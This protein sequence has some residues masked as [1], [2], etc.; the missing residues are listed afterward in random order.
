[1]EDLLDLVFF[2]IDLFGEYWFVILGYFVY[3]VLGIDKD[4]KKRKSPPPLTPVNP[5]MMPG[6]M[7]AEK[8]P[9]PPMVMETTPM[10]SREREPEWQPI[11]PAE[12]TRVEGDEAVREPSGAF[13]PVY[14]DAA[15]LETHVP[16]EPVHHVSRQT[17]RE[18]MKW[19]II[20]S[21]PRSRA[22]YTVPSIR[23]K[24]T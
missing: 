8:A 3:K 23:K 9:A 6:R 1:M 7:T 21:P 10:Q 19:S 15:P 14:Q 17:L 16:T 24:S 18:G 13:V 12:I 2:L 22:P 20:L 4:K 11:P 5:D